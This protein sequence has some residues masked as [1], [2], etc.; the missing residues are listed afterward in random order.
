MEEPTKSWIQ[1]I[2]NS[3]TSIQETYKEYQ[4][5]ILTEGD[6]ECHVF[7]ALMAQEN[8]KG[9]H[10]S[11]G[12][13]LGFIVDEG[14]RK[15]SFVHSQVTWFKENEKSGFE[16]DLTIGSPALLEVVNIE[17][18]EE[19]TSKGFAY[20]G[21]AV[22]IELKFIRRKDKASQ[23]AHEDLLKIMN[24]LIPAKYANIENDKYEISSKNNVA[25]VSIV[26]CKDE[27]TYNLS[28][29]YLGKHLMLTKGEAQDNLFVCLFSPEKITWCKFDMIA[30]YNR[31]ESE[32]KNKRQQKAL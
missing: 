10:N 13:S 6:L 17:L 5:M 23:T 11:K 32:E 3:M 16:V 24:R 30:E 1:D 12:N 19:Y 28:K 29:Y 26:G 14:E 21:P 25:F 31:V 7:N 4:G 15:T 18:F 27:E 2:K 20:D 8:L 9:Y 22:A